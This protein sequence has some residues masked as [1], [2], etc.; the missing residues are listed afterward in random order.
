MKGSFVAKLLAWGIA[1]TLVALPIVGV[2]NGWFASDRW[3]V[4]RLAV[5]AEFNHVS[6]EQIRA[7]AEPQLGQGFFAIDLDRV[8]DAVAR[9]PEVTEV[10][11]AVTVSVFT[12][13]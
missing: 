9:L 13:P 6:A 8:R 12:R 2:L 1:L 7:V 11:M 5:S 3:P 10:T 4:T